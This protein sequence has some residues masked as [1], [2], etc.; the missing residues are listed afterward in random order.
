MKKF[1]FL[2]M[3]FAIAMAFTFVSC[4]EKAQPKM[5]GEYELIEQNGKFG[6]KLGEI[7]VLDPVYEE[8]TLSEEY[9]CVVAKKDKETSLIVD[10]HLVFS[11]EIEAIKNADT[12]GYF[13]ISTPNGVHL[14][15]GGTGNI[16]GRFEEVSMSDNIVF[17]KSED[18]W[19]AAFADHSPI[20]PHRFEKVYVAKN[21]DTH[22]VL[23]YDK[24]T[25][26]A[27]YDKGGVTDGVKY[28][29]SSKALKKQL[30]K[31]DT[32]KPCGVIE[33]NWKL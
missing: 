3:L 24:K 16:I 8:I 6:L 17:F 23:V 26:W 11:G 1:V 31:F 4:G 25:G 33:V 13:I 21:K 22:A 5:L 32:S 20:A 9:S 2:G 12:P 29:T 14:W 30:K 7:K 18:G 28:S 19:G 10:G 27:M 15:Q